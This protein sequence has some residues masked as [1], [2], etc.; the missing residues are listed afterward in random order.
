M[1]QDFDEDRRLCP[2]G[3]CI[4]VLDA[5]GRCKVCG[6]DA[7]TGDAPYRETIYAEPQTEGAPSAEGDETDDDDRHLCPDGSCIGL[8]GED[9]R[10]KVCGAPAP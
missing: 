4:G 2:D 7:A 8:L 1:T 6:R 3:S 5:D 9:G 10:C